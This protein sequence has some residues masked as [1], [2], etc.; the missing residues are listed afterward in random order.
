[1]YSKGFTLTEVLVTLSIVAV[2]ITVIVFNQSF[3]VEA[4]ALTNLADEITSQIAQAQ[5]Y[6]I[7]VKESTP[8]SSDFTGSYG[9]TFSLLPSGS[10]T[11]YLSF[12]D[13][14][15]N[16]VYDGSWSCEIGTSFECLEKSNIF[17]GNYID[18]LCVI[19]SSGGDQCGIPQ[20]VDISFARPFVEARIKLFNNGGQEYSPGNMVGVRIILKSTSGLS[21]SVSV[22]ENGQIS[23]Q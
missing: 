14:D 11:N 8:G 23:T 15:G 2:I 22:Y 6:G 3:Y 9:L 10:N 7:S 17:R 1:M 13:K 16:Q 19:R 21:R 12:I 5:I 4:A 20:R 18:E